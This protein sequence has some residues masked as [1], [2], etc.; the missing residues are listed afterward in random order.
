M[1]DTES[2]LVQTNI[3]RRTCHRVK[4]MQVLVLGLCRTGTLSTWLALQELGYETYH[5]TS[6]MQNPKDAVLWTE[7]FRGKYHDGRPFTR[8]DWDQLLGHVEAVTDFPAAVFVEELVAAYPDAKVVLTLRDVDAWYASMQQTIMAQ[9]YSPL[10]TL[11]GWIDPE[12]FGEGN[13]MCRL[14]FDAMFA[15]DFARN[16]KQAFREHY[17]RVR[18][19]VPRDRLLEWNPAEG[20]EPLCGFLG[21]DVPATP[22]PRANEKAIFQKKSAAVVRS[23]FGRFLKKMTCYG[24]GVAVA[25]LVARHGREVWL[26]VSRWA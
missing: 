5:M 19:V 12:K 26:R 7:A 22:F 23:A 10:A 25:Y 15:G 1:K 16:G 4:P 20:W 13:R 9:T 24:V 21:K 2:V 6:I 3:D 17:D 14:G 8:A 11:L 18:S